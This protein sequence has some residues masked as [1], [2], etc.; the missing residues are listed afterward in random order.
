MQES[1]SEAPT[2]R[3]VGTSTPSQSQ[4]DDTDPF[5]DTTS[6]TLVQDP[7]DAPAP[8]SRF[9]TTSYEHDPMFPPGLI[10]SRSWMTS[11][12]TH[13]DSDRTDSPG[14]SIDMYEEAPPLVAERW[15]FMSGGNG[16]GRS[17]V[18]FVSLLSVID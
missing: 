12:G 5:A 14:I 10:V 4:A 15:R 7:L 6:S 13:G 16:S 18:R 3:V 17:S 1:V 9:A 2:I 11:S 8:A